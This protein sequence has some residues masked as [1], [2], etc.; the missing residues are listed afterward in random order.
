MADKKKKKSNFSLRKLIYN[1]KY[2]IFISIILAVVIW[3]ATSMSLSPQTTKTITVTA[4]VDFTDSAASQLGIKCYGDETVNVDVTIS[5]KKYLAK[6]ITA[7]D[8]NVYLQTNYATSKGTLEIPIR[9]EA[10]E[11]ANFTIESY[12]PTVYKAYFD[13][14]DEKNMDIEVAYDNT[15]FIEDGYVMGEAVLSEKA[16]T[17]SG[18]QTYLSQ[19]DRV[20]ANV[21]V[22]DKLSE[23]LTLDLQLTA[24][25]INGDEV[26]YVEILTKNETVTLTIPV[27]KQTTLDVTSSFTGNP[28]NIDTSDFTVAYSVD[29]VNAGVLDG[30]DIDTANVGNIDFSLLTV[31]ENVFTFNTDDIESFTVLDDIDEITVTVTVPD[32]YSTEEFYVDGANVEILNLPD[33][34]KA[35]VASLSSY[36][37]TVVGSEDDLSS[38][39]SSDIK[40]TIDLSSITDSIESGVEEY[41]AVAAV[42][43]SDTCWIYGNYTAQ[44]R[45]YQE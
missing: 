33:G 5:C 25:D 21:S 24:V 36:G 43:G 15:D 1:D 26:S 31:G 29:S 27:L 37:I 10:D 28:G 9:A 16:V 41:E 44:I 14:E 12:Y 42:D 34:Y 40:L 8:I 2:L 4:T 39:S 32:T 38:L 7:D 6:D 11:N 23:S 18:A 13:V 20:V 22:D 35:E 45:I 19:V 17:V 3:C 30:T